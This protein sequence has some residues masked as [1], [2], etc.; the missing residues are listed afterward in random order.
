M[1]VNGRSEAAHLTGLIPRQTVAEQR[2][3]A[4]RDLL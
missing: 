3:S 1:V 2:L 4:T